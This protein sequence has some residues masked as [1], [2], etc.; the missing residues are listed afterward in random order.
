MNLRISRLDRD[1]ADAYIRYFDERAFSDGSPEKGCYCVW[2]H[3]TDRH[4]RDRSLMPAELRPSCK[5][6]YARELIENGLLNGFAAWD[7]D[8]I[9]GFCNA[10]LKDRY[11]RL[12]RVNNPASWTGLGPE[13]RILSVVC[14]IVAPDMRRQGIA[15]ALL[16]HACQYAADNGYDYV[17]GYPPAGA[18][19][20]R[21]CGGSASMYERLGFAIIDIPHG[22]IARKK[23]KQDTR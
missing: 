10:D 23:L 3:W 14:F 9:V 21:D 1:M 16:S 7:G 12:S 4:E 11:F 19:T 17:E 6:N 8:Q 18:F 13:D 22:M 20:P 2:H 5:R 15:K